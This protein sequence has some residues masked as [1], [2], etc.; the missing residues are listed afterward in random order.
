MDKETKQA[1]EEIARLLDNSVLSDL[2]KI[3][4]VMMVMAF[5]MA[6]FRL[7][8]ANIF[9]IIEAYKEEYKKILTHN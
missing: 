9:S 5:M 1:S 7:R 8:S 3:K 2:E 4:C 6:K